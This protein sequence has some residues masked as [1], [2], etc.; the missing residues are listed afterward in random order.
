M[1]KEIK[2]EDIFTFETL[3]ENAD[4]CAKGVTW[5]ASVQMFILN[6]CLWTVS[7][8]NA[9]TNGKYKPR[10][11]TEFFIHERGK[12]RFIQANHISDRCVQKTLCNNA[13]KPLIEPLLIT[14]NPA[15]RIDKG[16]KFMIKRLR[17]HLTEHYRKYGLKGGIL[18]IDL[19]DYFHSIKQEILL[20]KLKDIIRDE[21]IFELTKK[22]V[23][24]FKNDGL[25]LGSEVSQISAIFYPN[26]IDHYIKE[27]L[28]IR[29]YGRFMDDS[30]IISEDI[31]YLK[32]CQNII[33]D[34]Y[35]DIGISIN[36]KKMNITKFDGGHFIF[37]KR[38]I[39]LTPSGKIVMRP[40]RKNIYDRR[41]KLRRQKKLLENGEIELF[42]IRQSYNSWRGQIL[43]YSNCWDMIQRTDRLYLKLFN[44]TY[45]G[46]TIEDLR[47]FKEFELNPNRDTLINW[48]NSNKN[49]PQKRR[50]V[51]RKKRKYK[52]Y[53]T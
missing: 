23:R 40:V 9:L 10:N 16:T 29:G 7:L 42:S 24:Q 30:Y 35:A 41:R 13:L 46:A 8:L 20:D 49:I 44:E 31:E 45:D 11:F 38:K 12:T 18:I 19:H 25:G 32:E 28:H 17:R 36:P 34:M 2:F 37:M 3:M 50:L 51:K 52:K 4:K 15:S 5:K 48:I 27:Q 33:V 22:F 39:H 26:D 21:R 47:F 53:F 1:N 43:K 6:K 14:D